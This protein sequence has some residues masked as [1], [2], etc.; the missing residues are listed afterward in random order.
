M[1]SKLAY[2][3]LLATVG[4]GDVVPVS[5]PGKVVAGVSILTA[6]ILFTLPITI[7]SASL[8]EVYAQE[9]ARR[10]QKRQQR[11]TRRASADNGLGGIDKTTGKPHSQ[12]H[13]Q[14][15]SSLQSASR[16]I[17]GSIGSLSHSHSNSN[18]HH[19]SRDLI[20]NFSSSP[21]ALSAS[22]PTHGSL[23]GLSAS[24]PTHGSLQG[25]SASPPTRLPA[26][27][28]SISIS[29]QDIQLQELK[30]KIGSG[31]DAADL[32]SLLSMVDTIAEDIHVMQAR[33]RRMET[34]RQ[35]LLQVIKRRVEEK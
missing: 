25:L 16:S 27:R 1:T 7:V 15:I 8:S 10:E 6:N 20:S 18:D 2:S 5:I 34:N 30:A 4:Y 26:K 9:N 24:S 35:E 28:P 31:P 14:S 19:G 11:L 12:P 23:Q 33:L 3:I 29:V 13:R 21:D 32:M 22:S 17:L